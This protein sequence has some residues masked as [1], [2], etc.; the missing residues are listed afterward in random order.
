MATWIEWHGHVPW[1]ARESRRALYLIAHDPT[2]PI[3]GDAVWMHPASAGYVSRNWVLADGAWK[4]EPPLPP[5]RRALFD[6]PTGTPMQLAWFVSVLTLITTPRI[7]E[8]E[9]ADLGR[10]NRARSKHGKGELVGYS[11]VVLRRDGPDDLGRAYGR[12]PA[13]EG[14]DVVRRARHHVRT[15]WR[16]RRGRVEIVRTHWR[17]DESLGTVRQVH[18]VARPEERAPRSQ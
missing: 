5:E 10:L 15:H 4:G 1:S 2:R 8:R 3:T 16:L 12:P 13:R 6:E 18:H 17:G 14:E 11:S 7:F 9:P